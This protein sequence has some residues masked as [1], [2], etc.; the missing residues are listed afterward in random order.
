MIMLDTVK[1]AAFHLT[2]ERLPLSM[3]ARG[4]AATPKIFFTL[5]PRRR[6]PSIRLVVAHAA[7]RR[8][9]YQQI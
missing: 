4:L 2:H 1:L 8:K 7:A 3:L 9:S 5:I 6:W